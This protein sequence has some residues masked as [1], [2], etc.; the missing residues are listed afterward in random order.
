[1]AASDQLVNSIALGVLEAIKPYIQQQTRV[2]NEEELMRILGVKDKSTMAT[3]RQR[4][5]KGHRIDH[6][7][8]VYFWDDVENFIKAE[9]MEW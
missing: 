3:Y 5:L 9:G 7:H 4:G 6:R 2:I 8:R 1:M